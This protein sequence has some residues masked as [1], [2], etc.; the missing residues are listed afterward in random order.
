MYTETTQN[1]NLVI[2][3]LLAIHCTYS[4]SVSIEEQKVIVQRALN[5]CWLLP[6]SQL[7][8]PDPVPWFLSSPSPA[9]ASSF[10]GGV[11]QVDTNLA[12]DAGLHI[13]LTLFP[14]SFTIDLIVLTINFESET[15]ASH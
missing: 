10:G 12:R 5:R 7:W 13:H 11:H 2:L 9:G 15:S 14:S 4:Y 1:F 6:L 3:E 8:L